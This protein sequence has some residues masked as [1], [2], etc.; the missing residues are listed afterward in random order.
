MAYV[1]LL[2]NKKGG[3]PDCPPHLAKKQLTITDF[4]FGDESSE[5]YLSRKRK[6]EQRTDMHFLHIAFER[7]SDFRPH[8][9]RLDFS[10]LIFSLTYGGDGGSEQENL[11][12]FLSQLDHVDR[13]RAEQRFRV[14]V[15]LQIKS[16]DPLLEKAIYHLQE[17]PFQFFFL[18]PCLPRTLENAQKINNAFNYLAYRGSKTFFPVGPFLGGQQTFDRRTLVRQKFI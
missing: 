8:I 12:K 10:N 16:T 9:E 11:R 2:K 18:S 15:S 4:E 14:A 17:K 7:F 3:I 13:I 6:I 1:S 5:Y